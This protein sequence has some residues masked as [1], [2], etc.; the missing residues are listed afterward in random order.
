LDDFDGHYSMGSDED[1]DYDN[2]SVF[3]EVEGKII[4]SA[5]S[6]FDHRK[7]AS[8]YFNAYGQEVFPDTYPN[9]VESD[10]HAWNTQSQDYCDAEDQLEASETYASGALQDN[11]FANATHDANGYEPDFEIN[12]NRDEYYDDSDESEDNAHEN[13]EFSGFYDDGYY[14]GADGYLYH[15]GVSYSGWSNGSYRTAGMI[16]SQAQWRTR[17]NVD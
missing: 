14:Y 9:G 12:G 6:S 11:D 4:S 13:H 7:S 2:D 15:D 1:P 17:L 5:A 8:R 3:D 16:Q 10:Q